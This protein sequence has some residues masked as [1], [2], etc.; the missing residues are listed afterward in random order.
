MKVDSPEDIRDY[1]IIVETRR[2]LQMA[3]VQ[4]PGPQ[5][6]GVGRVETIPKQDGRL[7]VVTPKGLIVS[8]R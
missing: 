4:S 8:M 6:P 3:E 1:G 7:V 2:G 5:L